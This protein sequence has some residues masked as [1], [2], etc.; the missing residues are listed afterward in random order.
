MT[1]GTCVNLLN[2]PKVLSAVFLQYVFCCN[3]MDIPALGDGV[4][5]FISNTVTNIVSSLHCC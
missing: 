5:Y 2:W 4:N 3:I 1:P